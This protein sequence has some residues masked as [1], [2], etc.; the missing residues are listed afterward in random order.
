MRAFIESLRVREWSKNLLLFAGVM[1][2]HHFFD[3][4]YLARAAA[5]FFLFSF[6]ASSIYL[7]NDLRD[8]EQDLLH[9]KKK[10]R[11]IA[12]GRLGAGAALA[13]A[14]ALA[15]PSLAAGFFLSRG[16]GISLLIYF[17]LNVAYTLRLKE[18]VLLDVLSISVGF[19]IRAIAGV[20]ALKGIDADVLI[21]PWLLVCTF[22]AALFLAV[23]KRRSE[24]VLLEKGAASHR[25]SL[26]QYSLALADQITAVTAGITVLSFSL[27]TIWPDTVAKFGTSS[28]IYTVPFV[29]YGLFRYM[30]LAH[31]KGLGGHP[32]EVLFADKPLL[33][34]LLLWAGAV[35]YILYR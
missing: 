2:S 9:P 35:L 28:L 4:A 25:A 33:V 6:V 13:G 15:I 31:E 24:L 17:A 22:F 19:V 5:G 12:S 20:E 27:Y 21:S 1:F 29:V 8:R 7:L 32:A 26:E 14:F 10:N 34:N 18:V 23:C 30:Y 16:F 11:P 3:P